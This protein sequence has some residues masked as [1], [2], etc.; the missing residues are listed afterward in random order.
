MEIEH[1]AIAFQFGNAM[2]YLALG[3][4]DSMP[5]KAPSLTTGQDNE[6]SSTNLH[7]YCPCVIS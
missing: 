4:G 3:T 2:F 1:R 6:Q 5:A 7:K